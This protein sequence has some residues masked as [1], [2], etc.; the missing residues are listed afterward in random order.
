MEAILK[1]RKESRACS[2]VDARV[3]FFRVSGKSGNCFSG[4]GAGRV[5]PELSLRVTGMMIRG[6]GKYSGNVFSTLFERS[7]RSE[8]SEFKIFQINWGPYKFTDFGC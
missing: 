1:G 6:S 3:T 8:R 2:I 4:I 5:I 7:E